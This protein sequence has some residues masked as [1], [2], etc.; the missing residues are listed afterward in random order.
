MKLSSILLENNKTIRDAMIKMNDNALDTLMIVDEQEIL[1]GVITDGDIRRRLLKNNNLDEKVIYAMNREFVSASVKD[2]REDVLEL[3]KDGIKSIPLVD[4]NF[5]IIG[6]IGPEIDEYIPIYDTVFKGNELKYLSDCIKKSWVSSSGEYVKLFENEF[7]KYT[8]LKN[9]LSTSSG[10]TA[11]EIALSLCNLNELDEIIV[12]NLTFASPLNSAIRTRAKIVLV[13]VN[14][15]NMCLNASE[16]IKKVNSKTKVIIVVNLYGYPVDIQKI[17][18]SIAREILIIEDCAESLGSFRKQKHCGI[19]SDFATF[20][21]FGNKTITT[22]E[23]GMLFCA[24]DEDKEKA[25]L[26]RDH[27]MSRSKKYWHD[28]IGF[29]FRITNLQAA[30]GLAQLER[31]EEILFNK[32]EVFEKYFK[33]LSPYG[34]KFNQ[35][36]QDHVID[37]RWLITVTHQNIKEYGVENLEYQLKLLGIDIRKVFYPLSS[38]PLYKQY[39]YCNYRNSHYLHN[40]YICLPSS[41]NLTT[42]QIKIISEKMIMLLGAKK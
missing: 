13:D 27:G 25:L 40:S 12:P 4:E 2:K 26:L 21:F 6:C 23:G 11:L 18:S 16:I 20:S 37:S 1:I 38:M 3:R 24:K 19:W 5:K 22:G 30:V 10:S 36:D 29:N 17:R 15:D 33:Y 14:K 7:S 28:E 31:I 35:V 8:R 9:C 42:I 34:F 41:P 39:C 32:R